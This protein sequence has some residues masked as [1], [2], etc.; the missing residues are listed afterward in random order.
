MHIPSHELQAFRATAQ[1]LSF[2][3]AAERIH[4]TQSALSQRVQTLERRLGVTLFVRDRKSTKL[5]EAGIRLLR[6]CQTKD[7]LES[8]L[9]SDLIEAPA[10]KL[11]GHLRVAA[12]SSVLHSV[13]M[14]ALAP[15]LRDNPAIQFEFSMREMKDLPDV[16][17]RGEADFVIMSSPYKKNNIMTHNIGQEHYVL[18]QSKSHPINNIYLDHDPEDK[19][20]KLFFKKQGKESLDINRSYVD[21]IDGII[22]GVELGLGQG[23]VP[24]HLLRDNLSVRIVKSFKTMNSP[25]ILHYFRQ[26]YYSKLQEV[27]IDIL[28]KES[29]NLL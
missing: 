6:Y 10:G 12:F 21:D 8:E 22:K 2:S 17:I 25:V 14:P 7:H 11:G 23:I 15:L 4:I 29:A 27:V 9:I 16:L 18:I 3:K 13:I 19:F 28:K 26:P 24:C 1:V 20:T 5:T